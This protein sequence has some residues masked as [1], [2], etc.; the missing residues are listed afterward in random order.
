MRSEVTG[1]LKLRKASDKFKVTQFDRPESNPGHLVLEPALR[2][3]V[4]CLS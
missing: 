1:E 4:Y 2:T 3:M